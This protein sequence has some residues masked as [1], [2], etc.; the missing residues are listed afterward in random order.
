MAKKSINQIGNQ[1]F[2]KNIFLTQTDHLVNTFLSAANKIEVSVLLKVIS[3]I[4]PS[5][6]W[7]RIPTP[8]KPLG[9]LSTQRKNQ[10]DISQCNR[11][12]SLLS[13]KLAN[14]PLGSTKAGM[15]FNWETGTINFDVPNLFCTFSACLFLSHSRREKT[16]P[17][18]KLDI[19]NNCK[20]TNIYQLLV[21][22]ICHFKIIRKYSVK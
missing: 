13:R 11:K 10:T 12:L 1:A 22:G 3:S 17:E 19:F 15:L 18:M 2:C 8:I 20:N 7:Y 5:Q 21:E 14:Q 9:F 16:V 6:D 4:Q